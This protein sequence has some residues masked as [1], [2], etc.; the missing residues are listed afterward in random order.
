MK[1]NLKAN[2]KKT[3]KVIKESGFKLAES[4]SKMD[5][6][7]NNNR[8]FTTGVLKV[9]S[10]VYCDEMIRAKNK[11]NKNAQLGNARYCPKTK[12]GYCWK[13]LPRQDEASA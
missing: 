11:V 10:K 12:V 6:D 4:I 9:A 2:Q 13:N 1:K 5:T 8:K 7:K 3:K